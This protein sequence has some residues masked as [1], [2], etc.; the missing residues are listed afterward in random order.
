MKDVDKWRGLGKLIGDAV[1]QGAGAI[2]RVHLAT[3]KRNFD[4]LKQVPGISEPVQTVQTVHDVCVATS[5]ETVRAVTRAVSKTV[6]LALTTL[7]DETGQ[8]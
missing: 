4:L 2:E 3:A 7:D 1:E 8:Q 6:D 5:Y